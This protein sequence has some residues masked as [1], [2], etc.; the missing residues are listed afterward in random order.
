[1]DIE[2]DEATRTATLV[3]Q[4]VAPSRLL[5]QSQGSHQGLDNGNHFCGL[6]SENEIFERTSS[7]ALAFD[8]YIGGEGVASYRASKDPWVGNPPLHELVLF[9]Y[10]HN[11][12]SQN[13]YYVSWNGATNVTAYRFFVSNSSSDDYVQAATTRKHF[14]FET[15]A[16]GST[17]GL[18]SFA[19][20]L[21]A[22]GNVLG[23][24][25]AVKTFVPDANLTKSCDHLKC[26]PYTDYFTAPQA[27]VAIEM[28]YVNT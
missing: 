22:D 20:A 16:L 9:T 23:R 5:S 10:A 19:E 12:S 4:A 15:L 21:D 14:E 3:Y 18:H 2:I 25:A 27:I 24:T 8:A 17:F 28:K 7:G 6:G 11:A 13:A 26:A 1:M